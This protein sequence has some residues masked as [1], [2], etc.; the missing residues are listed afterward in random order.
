MSKLFTTSFIALTLIGALTLV[1]CGKEEEKPAPGAGL[2]ASQHSILQYVPADTP[3]VIASVEPLPDSLLDKIEPQLDEVLR[4]YEVLLRQ[5]LTMAQSEAEAEGSDPEDLAKASA[6]I[7]ELSSL[8]SVE[9][10]RGAGFGRDST[11]AIYGVGLLPVMRITVSDGALFDAALARIE[12]RAGEKMDVA[13]IGNNAFRFVEADQAKILI[14]TFEDQVVVSVVPSGFD[15]AQIGQVL[16][17]TPPTSNIAEAGVLAEIASEYGYTD[18]YIGFVDIERIVST[19]VGDANAIDA[20]LLDLMSSDTPEL[21][22][23]CKAEIKALAT[24]APRLVMGYTSITDSHLETQAVMELR[25]DIATGLTGLPAAVPGLSGDQGGLMSF[26]MSLDVMAAR[27]FYEARLD[28]LE[29]DPFECEQFAAMQAGVAAGRQALSQ[30]VPPMIY[31]FKGFLAVINDIEGLDLATNTPPTSMEG[32]MMLAMDNAPALLAMGA[33]FSPELAGLEIEPNGEPVAFD[34]PQMQSVVDSVYIALTDDALAMSFGEGME[35]ELAGMLSAAA[36][37]NG[38]V[39]SFSMDASRYYAFIGEAMSL[40][41][42]D[43]ENPMPPE[44][45]AAMNDIMVAFSG[46][47]DRVTADVRFTQRGVEIDSLITLKD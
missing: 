36:E 14:A 41:E 7:E 42:E 18:Q 46:F 15:D 32:R 4:S 5:V 40:A 1:A 45:Q 26:G 16:G 10:L 17:L 24:I 8:M 44:F 39:M 37:E 29:A 30:P 38:T 21:T 28:A 27:N 23:V 33:M 19:V 3:Y 31:D 6:V 12:A 43:D 13:M 22:D 2:L 20:A 9:G 47:Y 11:G 34:L 35:K 25:D